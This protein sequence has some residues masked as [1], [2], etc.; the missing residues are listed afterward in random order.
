MLLV[1]DPALGDQGILKADLLT[2]VW[3]FITACLAVAA[4]A[5]TFGG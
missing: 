4:L 3:T 5:V 2:T 1:G